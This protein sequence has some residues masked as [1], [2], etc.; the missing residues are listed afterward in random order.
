MDQ[1]GTPRLGFEKEEAPGVRG[2][3]R[4]H[5]ARKLSSPAR[6][7]TIYR[8]DRREN[9][10]RRGTGTSSLAM[11]GG[12]EDGLSYGA[13]FIAPELAFLVHREMKEMGI[14]PDE[15]TPP[16]GPNIHPPPLIAVSNDDVATDAVTRTQSEFVPNGSYE[17]RSSRSPKPAVT[18]QRAVTIELPRRILPSGSPQS[19]W[20]DE[21]LA[22]FDKVRPFSTLLLS[23]LMLGRTPAGRLGYEQPVRLSSSPYRSND[24]VLWTNETRAGNPW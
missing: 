19:S 24:P 15:E 20:V 3:R 21:F 14:I 13:S 18:L 12:G 4:G 17:L 8:P 2:G 5:A 9:I 22:T 1:K 11:K 16:P 6:L 23:S 10:L 7:P